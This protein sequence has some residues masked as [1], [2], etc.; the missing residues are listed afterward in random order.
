MIQRPG[1]AYEILWRLSCGALLLR[2]QQVPIRFVYLSKLLRGKRAPSYGYENSSANATIPPSMRSQSG[3][4]RG[5][6]S[7]HHPTRHDTLCD[8]L[9]LALRLKPSHKGSPP[10]T[11]VREGTLVNRR[12]VFC[13]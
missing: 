2:R 4:D 6:S 8:G 11:V 10:Q 3:T 9:R 7:S 5:H 1:R 12:G 13:L